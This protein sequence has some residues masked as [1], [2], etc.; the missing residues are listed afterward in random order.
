MTGTFV[1]NKNGTVG[2]KKTLRTWKNM[3]HVLPALT[4]AL[5]NAR[6]VSQYLDLMRIVNMQDFLK[7]RK[8]VSV[9]NSYSAVLW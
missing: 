5:R 6:Y 8:I 3:A 4:Q 2:K 9:Q 1:N 7:Q